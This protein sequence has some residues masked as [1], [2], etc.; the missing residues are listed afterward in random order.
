MLPDDGP[1]LDSESLIMPI[2][3]NAARFLAG[4]DASK[5]VIPE[6]LSP[7]RTVRAAFPHTAP[8]RDV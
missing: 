2:L 4:H 8:T 6:R 1:A 5:I 3:V 7:Q